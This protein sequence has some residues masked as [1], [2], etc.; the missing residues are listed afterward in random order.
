[1]LG[2]LAFGALMATVG[3]GKAVENQKMKNY[4]YEID[5]KG[6]PMWLDRECN[7][8]I[9]GEKVVSKVNYQTGNVYYAGQRSN[10]V[11]YD[12]EAERRKRREARNEE[13]R[14]KAI[15]SGKLAYQEE[16]NFKFLFDSYKYATKE[17]STG[18]YIAKIDYFP[19]KKECRKYYLAPDAKYPFDTIEDDEGV[20]ITGEEYIGI[21]SP[22]MYQSHMVCG[23]K[24]FYRDY[25]N[26]RI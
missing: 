22:S 5:D 24:E 21:G 17:I 1:M 6:R 7:R 8:Y 19:H 18:K 10:T 11:Y 2:V 25:R 20:I 16:V 12:P 23:E 4:T 14:K 15:L 26:G 13:R 3:I 9:N